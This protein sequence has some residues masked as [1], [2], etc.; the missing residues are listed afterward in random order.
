M[1]EKYRK[2]IKRQRFEKS[3]E[4]ADSGLPASTLAQTNQPIKTPEAPVGEQAS[5]ETVEVPS[6][7]E[8]WEPLNVYPSNPSTYSQW[9]QEL[10]EIEREQASDV[11]E[12]CPYD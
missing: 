9:Q 1:M 6:S 3:E 4:S 5:D 10:R 11:W 8:Y 2:L 12:S 7:P